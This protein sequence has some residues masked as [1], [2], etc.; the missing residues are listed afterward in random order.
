[1]TRSPSTDTTL[2]DDLG[3]AFVT[4]LQGAL[5]DAAP[6]LGDL[7]RRAGDGDFGDNVRTAMKNLARELESAEPEDYRG[8]VT[9]MS[10]AWLGVGGTSGP[11]FGMFYRDLAKAAGDGEAPDLGALAEALEAGQAVIQKYG[12]AEVGDR[13]MVDAL[14]P[15]V[16]AL[17]E[18]AGRND[19]NPQAQ[20]TPPPGSHPLSPTSHPPRVLQS[21]GS[22]TP[23]APPTPVSAPP[24]GPSRGLGRR[25]RD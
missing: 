7:D 23:H 15:A 2:P 18:A 6:A 5:E 10:R 17:R 3:P 25:R 8:W 24:A 20:R 9:A 11:L 4:A 16:T 21:S 12:E 14:A 1:M 13:T 19:P 22:R